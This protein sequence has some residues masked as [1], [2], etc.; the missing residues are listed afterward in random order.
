[1][2]KLKLYGVRHAKVE[3]IF[4]ATI[5]EGE[6]QVGDASLDVYIRVWKK[7]SKDEMVELV[8]KAGFEVIE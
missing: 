8:R 7:L 6:I 4:D 3:P 1:M 2:V 5:L